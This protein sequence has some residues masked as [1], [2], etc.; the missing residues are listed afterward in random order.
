MDDTING[1][2]TMMRGM[3]FVATFGYDVLKGCKA[4]EETEAAIK[5]LYPDSEPNKYRKLTSL[6]E[7]EMWHEI[8]YALNYRKVDD[9][10]GPH[11]ETSEDEARLSALAEAYRT[12]VSGFIKEGTEMYNLPLHG[13]TGYDVWWDYHIVLVNKEGQSLFIY[14]AA[15]D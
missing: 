5:K 7:E 6:T 2:N 11:L 8:N 1:L 9:N 12:Y 10:E 13:I 3:N 14:S 15:S 4:L